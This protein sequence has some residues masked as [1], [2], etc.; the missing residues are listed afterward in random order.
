MGGHEVSGVTGVARISV[1]LSKCVSFKAGLYSFQILGNIIFQW[2]LLPIR[3]PYCIYLIYGILWNA[4][5]FRTKI[6][7]GDH[8][9]IQTGQNDLFIPWQSV[10]RK[11]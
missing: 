7:K 9:Y 11:P 2:T 3:Q 10:S 1:R 6:E 4:Q 8:Y 5:S